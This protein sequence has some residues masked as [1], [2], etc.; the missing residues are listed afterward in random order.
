MNRI[1]EIARA[2]NNPGVDSLDEEI[3]NRWT[4]LDGMSRGLS[5]DEA[6]RHLI[7]FLNDI[8]DDMPFDVSDH[9][10]RVREV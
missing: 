1:I 9:F 8:D 2:S 4:R 6:L 3:S 7:E 10:F 5:P